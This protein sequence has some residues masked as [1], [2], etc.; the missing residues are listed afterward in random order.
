ME[1]SNGNL[2]FTHIKLKNWRNF[3]DAE[4]E[5]QSRAF[6][7]GA[8][9]SGKSNFLDAFRFLKD[10][11]DI[12][13]GFEEAIRRRGGVKYLRSLAARQHPDISFKTMVGNDADQNLWE[14]E[15]TFSQDSHQRPVIK[16]EKVFKENILILNRPD[17]EDKKDQE[18]MR[19]TFLQQT[20]ANLRFREVALFFKSIRYLH[21]V[22]QL[23]REPDRSVGRKNDPY[24]G[25]FLEQ[26]AGTP[27]NVRKARLKRMADALRV[28]VPQLKDLELWRDKKGPWHI[29]GK[30]VHW[31]PRGAWQTEEH[32]SDGT[33][34][35]IGLLWAILDGDGALLLEEPELSLHTEIVRHIPQIFARIQRKTKRQIL[36]STHSS[37][38]LQDRG[39][40][41]DETFLFEA[42]LEEGTK[43]TPAG[44]KKDI[45]ALLEKGLTLSEIVMP[46]TSPKNAQQLALFG[47]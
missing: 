18:R 11:V 46:Y 9:A 5:L 13:G 16:S 17:A 21:I 23:I 3:V 43:V 22:P 4:A 24:G 25:D 14:Y 36:V 12:G 26:I 39:I 45:I 34:R 30:Y 32:F 1:N 37:D 8:N 2:R 41:L 29:R 31:R 44:S 33:L 35:L 7:V 40:G 15:L 28:A 47:E 27:E 20:N 42:S 19:Q 38:L 10:I 6:L